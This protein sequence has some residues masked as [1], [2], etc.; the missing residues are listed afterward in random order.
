VPPRLRAALDRISTTI[1]G[2]SFA[3][4]TMSIL[5]ILVLVLGVTGLSLWLGQPQYVPLYTGVSASDAEAITTQL[6]TDNVSFQLTDGGGTIL[7][8]QADVYTE[9]LKAAANNLP[10]SANQGYSLLDTMGVT[11][12]EFQQDA[13]YKRAMEGELA[14]TV[15][16]MDGVKTASVKLA[17]PTATVFT[18]ATQDPTASV[19]IAENAGTT[20][21]GDQVQAIVHLVSASIV[22]MKAT[23][24]SVIDAAGNVLSTV[25]GGATG[26]SSGQ[27]AAYESSVKSSLQNMLDKV[28]GTGNST[29]VVNAQMDNS[30]ATKTTN[31][32]TIPTGTPQVSSSEQKE[33]YSGTGAAAAAG[34][35]GTTS[36]SGVSA[37]TNGTSNTTAGGAG[38]SYTSDNLTKDNALNSTTETQQI[39]SGGLQRETISVAVNRSA[40]AKNGMTVG[41]LQSLVTN[42]AGVQAA[43]GDAVSVQLLNFSTAG[44]QQAQQ[45]LAQAQAQAQQN[46]LAGWIQDGVVGGVIAAVIIGGLIVLR[47]FRSRP[48]APAVAV[49]QP[50]V[51]E[52]VFP[53]PAT[54]T[55][56]EGV[57]AARR[58]VEIDRLAEND[59]QRAAEFLRGLMDDRKLS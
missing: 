19:F 51:F 28:L 38:G 42:A 7:V 16:A 27:E 25:G 44:A 26:S 23:D 53:R 22:G 57:D 29:V 59:P 40:A 24:V 30:T 17:I 56:G 18:D 45:A 46:Q 31:T 36:T 54:P 49:E 14:N 48:D 2:F 20:L 47:R 10:S 32:Y 52:T 41:A 6:H 33:T 1:G 4:K 39:P 12:S 9:R 43:R 8:P 3:Q 35:L 37:S 11:T 34:V 50:A 58:R 5:G 21:S 15:D 13:T 55:T